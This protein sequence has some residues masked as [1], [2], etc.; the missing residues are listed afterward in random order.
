MKKEEEI[1]RE[2]KIRKK[3]DEWC[4]KNRRRKPLSNNLGDS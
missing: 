3:K 2:E 1:K 4:M